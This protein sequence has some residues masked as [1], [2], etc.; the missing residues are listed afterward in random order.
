MQSNQSLFCENNKVFDQQRVFLNFQDIELGSYCANNFEPFLKSPVA[1]QIWEVN[2]QE[3]ILAIHEKVKSHCPSMQGHEYK[4]TSN[5]DVDLY[6]L[7]YSYQY[8][9]PEKLYEVV[10]K[11]KQ[12]KLVAGYYS[13]QFQLFLLGSVL[14]QKSVLKV[15]QW[16]AEGLKVVNQQEF[17]SPLKEFQWEEGFLMLR[18]DGEEENVHFYSLDETGGLTLIEKVKEQS[19]W[20]RFYRKNE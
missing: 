1:F 20:L 19:P 8:K 4:I 14:G 6:R 15:Y 16:T 17:S 7:I 11:E 5:I 9:S 18:F 12:E 3:S 10:D 2:N 13:A